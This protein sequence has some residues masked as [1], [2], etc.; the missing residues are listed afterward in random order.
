MGTAFKS[1]ARQQREE[2]ERKIILKHK[3]N[4]RITLVRFAKQ[5]LDAKEY[6]QALKNFLDY[7]NTICEVKEINGIY[8]LHPK[9]FNPSR[10]LTE[11]LMISHIFFELARLY[12]AI[13]KFHADC[14]QCLEL[15]VLFSA[16]QPYQM[17]NSEMIRKHL[18]KSQFKQPDEF[19]N[20]Y[21][22]IFVQSRKCYVVT[23]CFGDTH[24]VTHQCREFKAWLLQQAWGPGLVRL[25]YQYSSQAVDRWGQSFWAHCISRWLMRPVLLLFS[26]AILPL[27]LK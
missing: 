9:H 21:Q 14:K 20:A 12:D 6:A 26:K 1:P 24:S 2:R 25:Y 17:V 10:E 5:Y 19:R 3:Y 13:P 18:K 4:N 16:N 11:M 22:Q 27:I 8:S 15:F 7:L 23:F